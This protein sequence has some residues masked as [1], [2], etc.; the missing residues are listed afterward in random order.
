MPESGFLKF[1]KTC[2]QIAGLTGKLKKVEVLSNYLISLTDQELPV[3]ATFLTG[4][5]F[6][7]TTGKTLQVGWAIIRKALIQASGLSETHFRSIS[8]GYGDAG[9]VA[10][11]VLLGRTIGREMTIQE[12]SQRFAAMQDAIGPVAKT[13]ILT[14]WLRTARSGKR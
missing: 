8:A 7:R 5:A 13:A 3:V 10:Y 4:N 11:E 1:A 9:R 14:D 6:S 2:N 12:V